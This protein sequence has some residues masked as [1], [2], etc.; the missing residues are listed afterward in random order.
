LHRTT[1]CV[2]ATTILKQTERFYPFPGASRKIPPYKFGSKFVEEGL[3]ND[4]SYSETLT[5]PDPTHQIKDISMF[6]S[7]ATKWN[8]VGN[9]IFYNPHMII[10]TGRSST[11]Y[12]GKTDIRSQTVIGPF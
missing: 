10:G 2:N 5:Q 9:G 11:V 7:P 4:P 6:E 12:K 3:A 1:I 8:S